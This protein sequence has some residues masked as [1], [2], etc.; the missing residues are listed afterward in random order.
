MTHKIT[1]FIRKIGELE[2]EFGQLEHQIHNKTEEISRN[3]RTI[4]N[5]EEQIS[6]LTTKHEK[7]NHDFR[8]QE[9]ELAT[10]K[11]THQETFNALTCSQEEVEQMTHKITSLLRKI[12]ELE[13]ECG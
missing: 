4:L 12:G 11:H 10:L 5:L 8:I 3:N 9:S 1:A 13:E 2:E 6:I 7:L